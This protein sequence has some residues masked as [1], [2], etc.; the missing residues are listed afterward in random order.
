M[1]VALGTVVL[2]LVALQALSIAHSGLIFPS[3]PDIFGNLIRI[4]STFG[5]YLDMAA[6]LVRI[7]AGF[8]VVL[9]S[10]VS[11]AIAS[12]RCNMFHSVVATFMAIVKATPLASIAL[13]LFFFMKSGMIPSFA[14]FLLAFP[15]M[16]TY[17]RDSFLSLDRNLIALC[18]IYEVKGFRRLVLFYLPSLAPAI[19]SSSKAA[20]SLIIKVVISSEILVYARHGIGRQIEDASLMLDASMVFAWTIV[21][22]LLCVLS[23]AAFGFL[24]RKLIGFGLIEGK[25]K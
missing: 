1:L 21:A 11:M 17:V 9:L 23:D 24:E 12:C 19:V 5:F 22:V 14:A 25:S 4:F 18:D 3:V 13:I 15:V 8:A 20:L 16:F 6:T 7:F 10:S 2:I